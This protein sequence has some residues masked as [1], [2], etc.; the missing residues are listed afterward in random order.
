MKKLF[1]NVSGNQFKAISEDMTDPPGINYGKALEMQQKVE[2]ALDELT[3]D[4][5]LMN[6]IHK[7]PKCY[8]KGIVRDGFSYEITIS[9]A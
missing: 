7:F 9:P 6:Y 4:Q 3:G 2:N 5:E 8:F 1:E